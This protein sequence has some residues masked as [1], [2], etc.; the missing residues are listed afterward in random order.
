MAPVFCGRW[1]H[2]EHSSPAPRPGCRP[3]SGGLTSRHHCAC[4]V[5][6]PLARRTPSPTS[7]PPHPS[8]HHHHCAQQRHG[9]ALAWDEE[10]PS[11]GEGPLGPTAAVVQPPARQLPQPLQRPV[12]ESVSA[13]FSTGAHQG[14]GSAP[15]GPALAPMRAPR[16]EVTRLF[17]SEDQPPR[18]YRVVGRTRFDAPVYTRHGAPGEGGAPR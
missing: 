11:S 9:P 13:L 10:S 18:R 12:S 8:H 17:H 6:Q 7:V 2:F 1:P 5:G 16:G 14:H 4:T 3:C 15:T